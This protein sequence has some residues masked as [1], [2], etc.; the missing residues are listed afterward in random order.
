MCAPSRG[1]AVRDLTFLCFFFPSLM[2]IMFQLAT[3]VFY[4]LSSANY[5]L[6]PF[7]CVL[8]YWGEAKKKWCGT[9]DMTCPAFTKPFSAESGIVVTMPI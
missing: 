1:P 9:A 6:P 7:T 4:L 2:E 3:F 8:W 5:H